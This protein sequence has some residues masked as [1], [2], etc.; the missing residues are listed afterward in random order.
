MYGF[1]GHIRVQHF[2]SEGGGIAEEKPEEIGALRESIIPHQSKGREKIS[3]SQPLERPSEEIINQVIEN[4]SNK[5]KR[6]VLFYENG[7]F[8][9]F[10]P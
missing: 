2:E 8:E 9:S 7:K 3:D 1:S 6:I 10:E 5:I 4:Q